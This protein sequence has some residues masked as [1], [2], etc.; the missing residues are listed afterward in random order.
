MGS[1]GRDL[2]S[3]AGLVTGLIRERIITGEFKPNQQLK[4]DELCKLFGVSRPPIREAFKTLEAV[5]LVEHKPRRGVFVIE[6][7]AK[8]VEE[9]YTIVAMLYKKTTEV[10]LESVTDDFLEDMSAH[11]NMMK[12]S[13]QDNP[14]NLRNYQ[15]AHRDF[16]ETI[17]EMAG[18]ER[19]VMLDKQFRYQLDTISYNT[20]QNP[21]R[22]AISLDYHN[23]IL[24]A[25]RERDK[26]SCLRLME[27]HIIAPMEYLINKF[28][29]KNEHVDEKRQIKTA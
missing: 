2:P 4:E 17:M 13:A 10:T 7:T 21:D 6:F 16:H 22:L 8:D 11:V 26:D 3:L 28:S 27:E 19:M 15:S 23:R 5:G 20:Y 24:T 18:N 9:I 12:I 1:L 14:P 29:V 25:F